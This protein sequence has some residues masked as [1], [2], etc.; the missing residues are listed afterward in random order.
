MPSKR[1]ER[2]NSEIQRC[3]ADVIQNRL[4]DP[5]LSKLLYVSEVNVTPDFK[6][7]KVK[8]SQDMATDEEKQ[9]TLAVLKKS[10]G[11]IKR[12]LAQMVHMPQMPKLTF[13]YD[14]GADASIRINEIL[15]NLNIPKDDG[16]E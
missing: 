12:E 1:I 11:F 15:R 14:K 16:E 5:R 4:N 13:E 8:I 2:A 9:V 7:C 3:L 10:E 6:Y